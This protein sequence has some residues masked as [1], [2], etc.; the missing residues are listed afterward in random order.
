M[1]AGLAPRRLDL[2]KNHTGFKFF[3]GEAI[4]QLIKVLPFGKDGSS[5]TPF[6]LETETL[7]QLYRWLIEAVDGYRNLLIAEFL[8][9]VAQHKG[10]HLG[11][12][13]FDCQKVGV[14]LSA[15]LP[16]FVNHAWRQRFDHRPRILATYALKFVSIS[17]ML[18]PPNFS[19]H[20][21]VSAIASIASPTTPAAGTTHTSLRS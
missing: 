15:S 12:I 11:C 2:L 14:Y 4:P 5:D 9:K 6:Q 7:V 16:E 10:E 18:S 20:A 19:S 17:A 21:S 3:F 13:P 1:I 8:K